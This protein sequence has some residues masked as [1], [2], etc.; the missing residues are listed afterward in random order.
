MVSE[1]IEI[2]NIIIT[3]LALIS[4]YIIMHIIKHRK[5]CYH[6][7]NNLFKWDGYTT[8][9][10]LYNR[11][12][13][14]WIGCNQSQ[15]D[16]EIKNYGWIFRG[17]ITR[18]KRYTRIERFKKRIVIKYHIWKKTDSNGHPLNTFEVIV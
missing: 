5:K 16:M 1:L 13:C 4:P 15:R 11:W 10:N 12:K 9:G 8:E 3:F 18:S 14:M 2:V 17:S 6:C 7:G